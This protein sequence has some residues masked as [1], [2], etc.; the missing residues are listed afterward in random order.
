MIHRAGQSHKTLSMN[1]KISRRKESRN[2]E[3]NRRRLLTSLTP[4]RWATSAHRPYSDR[5]VVVVVVF[6]VFLRPSF[7]AKTG[8]IHN[9]DTTLWP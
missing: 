6:F 5:R 1:Y 2:G 8:V 9:D 7:A 3:S 4:Y